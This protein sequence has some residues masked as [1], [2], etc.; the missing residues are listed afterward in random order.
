VVPLFILMGLFVNKGGISRELYQVSNAFLGHFRG[1]LAMATIAA[2]GGFAAICG[3]SLATAATM[4]KV[5][6]PEMRK[7]GYSDRTLLRIDR[8]RRNARHPDPAFRHPGDLR[9]ADRDLDRQAV[10]RRHHSRRPGH[11]VL[12]DRRA[13]FGLPQ[14]RG[15]TCGTRFSLSERL[16]AHPR[17]LVGA[18]AL[19]SW[20]SAASTE[21]LI[22]GRST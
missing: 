17:R 6:M 11:H 8:G 3:S 15:R 10:H 12:P 20:S 22:S 4:S 14:S 5:V 16:E 9:F 21:R 13:D 7:L 19:S 1:G 2:C 18:A